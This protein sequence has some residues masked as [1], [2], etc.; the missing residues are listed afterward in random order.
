MDSHVVLNET[1]EMSELE[2]AE[3]ILEERRRNRRNR[4]Q[5]EDTEESLIIKKT[6]RKIKRQINSD[7]EDS[8]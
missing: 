7:S 1:H 8:N 6:C 3:M 2:L 5:V 4:N